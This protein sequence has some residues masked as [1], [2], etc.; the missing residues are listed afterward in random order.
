MKYVFE[1]GL[2]LASWVAFAWV[3]YARRRARL[4]ESAFAALAGP[5]PPAASTV[6]GRGSRGPAVLLWKARLREIGY[7]VPADD[8]FDAETAAATA[9]YQAKLGLVEDR[10]AGPR[11]RNIRLPSWRWWRR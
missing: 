2:V 7:V 9:A 1:A 5:P 10:I 3:S 8:V 4:R 6:L 11:T